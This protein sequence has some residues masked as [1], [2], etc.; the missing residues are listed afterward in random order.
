M[1]CKER[2]RLILAFALALNEQNHVSSNLDG[3]GDDA[4]R[5]QAQYLME[6]TRGF[7]RQLQQL[8]LVH[9]EEHGC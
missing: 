5:R 7:C 8:L 6:T 9:C 2:D 4:E 3:A 1:P